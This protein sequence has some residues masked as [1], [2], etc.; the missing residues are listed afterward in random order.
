[1]AGKEFYIRFSEEE[2]QSIAALLI[3]AGSRLGDRN[4]M[5]GATILCDSIEYQCNHQDEVLVK[6]KINTDEA[7]DGEKTKE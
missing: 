3:A 1:M 6:F 2:V 7:K 4:L 5:K